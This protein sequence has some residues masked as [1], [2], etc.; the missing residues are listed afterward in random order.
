MHDWP[1]LVSMFVWALFGIY[2][3][4]AAKNVAPAKDSESDGSRRLHLFMLTAAQILI[5]F[6]VFGLRQRYLP[7]SLLV[8]V[9]GLALQLMCLLLAVWARQCLGRN[10]SGKIAIKVDHVLVRRGPYRLLR[11]PIYSALLGMYAGTAVV[12]GELH[13]LIGLALAVLA[14][15]RKVRLEEANLAKAFGAEY[16]DYRSKTWALFP[17]LY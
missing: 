12:W 5:F 17:G 10:W 2:W 14:Y 16:R 1:I 15:L 8:T 11:H 7:A 6:P 4:A 3:E 9:I 13:G